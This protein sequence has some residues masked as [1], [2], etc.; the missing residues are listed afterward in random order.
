[1]EAP[2]EGAGPLS[3]L[4]YSLYKVLSVVLG[5]VACLPGCTRLPCSLTVSGAGVGRLHARLPA[6]R[7]QLHFG[8]AGSST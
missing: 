5:W 6:A 4:W 1:M 2:P 3:T 7:L 8:P